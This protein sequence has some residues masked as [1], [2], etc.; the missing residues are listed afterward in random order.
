MRMQQLILIF[1]CLDRRKLM[2]ENEII[3]VLEQLNDY[4]KEQ[5]WMDFEII[6]YSKTELKIIGSIDISNKPN[7][8]LIF[9]DVFFVS[10]PFNWKT[11]TR[12]KVGMLLSG[13]EAKKINLK[14]QVEQ[15]YHIIKIQPE[16][17]P[18]EFGCLF[19]VKGASFNVL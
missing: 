6:E 10:T 4:L 16:D 19:G 18:E 12:K 14:Y 2:E 9:K 11:D 13:E 7:I 1:R 8:E 15:G 5:L 3:E 17:Y